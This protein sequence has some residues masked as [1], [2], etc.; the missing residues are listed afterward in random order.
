MS[1]SYHCIVSK[2]KFR[3]IKGIYKRHWTADALVVFT[4]DQTL[5]MPPEP[6]CE[7]SLVT[8]TMS[9]SKKEVWGEL[10]LEGMLERGFGH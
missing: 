6:C 7:W 1:T 9:V 2:S 4:F 5:A 10:D 3:R 8:R